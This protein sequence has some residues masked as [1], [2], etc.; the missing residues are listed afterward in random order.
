MSLGENLDNNSLIQIIDLNNTNL[1]EDISITPNH[2]FY[3]QSSFNTY[4][5]HYFNYFNQEIKLPENLLVL[6]FS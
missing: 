5:K 4:G 3:F 2:T 1:I 6:I